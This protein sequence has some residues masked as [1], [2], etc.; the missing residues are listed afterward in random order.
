VGFSVGRIARAF[1]KRFGTRHQAPQIV[2]TDATA[3]GEWASGWAISAGRHSIRIPKVK[4]RR[5]PDDAH[6][7]RVIACA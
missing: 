1:A 2:S 5:E 6:L 7:R 4:S 3:A